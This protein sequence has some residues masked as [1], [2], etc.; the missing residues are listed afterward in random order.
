MLCATIFSPIILQDQICS[1]AAIL[2]NDTFPIEDD[3]GDNRLDGLLFGWRRCCCWW[4]E[5]IDLITMELLLYYC[6]MFVC[7]VFLFY[8]CVIV[9]C[10]RFCVFVFFRNFEGGFFLGCRPYLVSPI[11]HSI[12]ITIIIIIFILKSFWLQYSYQS[13]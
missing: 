7:C 9:L 11:A 2:D 10:V 3:E 1:S 12:V 5:S 6:M 13:H 8:F 4:I